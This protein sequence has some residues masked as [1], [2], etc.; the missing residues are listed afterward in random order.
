MSKLSPLFNSIKA[1]ATSAPLLVGA[2]VLVGFVA[3]QITAL[4]G[5]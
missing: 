2:L 3:G 4:F 5:V 1:E